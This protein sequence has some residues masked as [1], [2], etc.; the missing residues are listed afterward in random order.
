MTHAQQEPDEDWFW[1]VVQRSLEASGG[2]RP[3]Q[4]EAIAGELRGCSERALAFFVRFH[5]ALCDAAYTLDHWGAFYLI[6][7]GCSED[8]LWFFLCW[9]ITRGRKSFKL[10]MNDPD[11]LADFPDNLNERDQSVE[12]LAR[13]AYEVHLAKFGFYPE[14]ELWPGG[15]PVDGEPWEA[16]E[17]VFRARWPKLYA[18]HWN[19]WPAKEGEAAGEN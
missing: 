15:A 16:E 11:S 9:L 18:K 19:R 13:V 5:V 3:K 12:D 2:D 1:A 4:N 7:G 6:S 17:A 14:T 8:E 10:W